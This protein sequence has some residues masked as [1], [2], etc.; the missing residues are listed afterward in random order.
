[1]MDRRKWYK[2]PRV[3]DRD[4]PVSLQNPLLSIERFVAF[5]AS[6]QYLT[7]ISAPCA[8]LVDNSR[9]HPIASHS[10]DQKT[11]SGH[12]ERFPTRIAHPIRHFMHIRTRSK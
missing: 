3:T 11:G 12:R 7:H 10:V 9:R 1:M 5:H 8:I 2:S 4:G 6:A